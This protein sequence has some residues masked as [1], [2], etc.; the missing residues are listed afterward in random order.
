LPVFWIADHEF[1]DR[2]FVLLH[3]GEGGA[4]RI[5]IAGDDLDDLRNTVRDLRNELKSE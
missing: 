4:V 5:T 2:G 3:A 1:S